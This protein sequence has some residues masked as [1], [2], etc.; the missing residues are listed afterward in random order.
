LDGTGG[1]HQGATLDEGQSMMSVIASL[2]IDIYSCVVTRNV[3][4]PIDLHT[5]CIW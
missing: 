4:S 1:I 3:S 2:C 5:H